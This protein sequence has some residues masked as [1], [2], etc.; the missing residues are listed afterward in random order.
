MKRLAFDPGG[1][2]APDVKNGM[3]DKIDNL[4][5]A[6]GHGAG[7]NNVGDAGAGHGHIC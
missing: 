6:A 4:G 2:V 7:H 1:H 5:G 3:Y